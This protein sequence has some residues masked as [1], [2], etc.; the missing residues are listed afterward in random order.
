MSKIRIYVDFLGKNVSILNF[1]NK[2]FNLNLWFNSIGVKYTSHFYM[3][4]SLEFV[5]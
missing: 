1:S 2:S 5:H 3:I 4:S